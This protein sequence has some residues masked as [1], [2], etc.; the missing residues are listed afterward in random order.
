MPVSFFKRFRR[1]L[2]GGRRNPFDPHVFQHITLIAFFAWVGMGADGISSANYGPE[3][4]YLALDG[5]LFLTPLLAFAIAAT[6]WIISLAYI[7][8]IEQF[9]TGGGGYVVASKLLHPKA[10]VLAGSG[11]IIDYVLTIAVSVVAGA[12]AIF[13]LLPERFDGAEIYVA[14]ITVVLLMVLNLRGLKESIIILLPLFLVFVV[15]HVGLVVYGFL[16]HLPEIPART[17]AAIQEASATIGSVGLLFVVTH[18]VHAFSMGA[19]TLTGIEAVSNGILTLKEPRVETGKRTMLYMAGSLSFIAAMLLL[20][21]FL[22]DTQHVAG[23]TMNAVLFSQ[24]TSGWVVGGFHVGQILVWLMM[25]SA[26]WLLIVAAQTGFIDGP[27]VI[28][29]MAQDS[30]LP[31]RFGHLS[32]RLVAQ[33]GIVIMGLAAIAFI[34]FAG[35]STRVLVSLYAIN[36]FMDF[37]L[38]QLGM[39]RLWW[40]RRQADPTWMRRCFIC[41]TGLTVSFVLLCI[42]VVVKFTHGGWLIIIVTGAVVLLCLKIQRHYREV[43]KRTQEI[44]Q[45]LMTMPFGDEH[46]QKQTLNPQEP[47]AVLLVEKYSGVGIHVLLNVQ[48]LFGARFKQFIF[49]TVG[50]ID[51]GRFKGADELESL[52]A[53]INRQADKYVLLARS[54]GLKAEARTSFAIDHIE[55]I[56]RLCLR[57]YDE[58]P[59]SVF[60]A[61]RL[62]FWKDTVWSRLLHNETPLTLQRRLMFHGLQFIVLPVRLQ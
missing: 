28:A 8:V 56:E 21:Y 25:I 43:K 34:L 38:A 33:N 10:G 1:R 22:F 19:G 9:P 26:A 62:L 27:R 2:I 41:A 5:M 59:N 36:V 32:E 6:V 37:S 30:W 58:F 31:H 51:S 35:G 53:E 20:N 60:F 29:N 11:L 42:M 18:F 55:E 46:V 52:K 47:T 23:K 49:V 61:A 39:S 50:A 17:T 24:I 13:S 7:Q 12:D 15:T 44:D 45:L 57:V 4:A 16:S 48:R 3:E 40:S 14:I 54:Y